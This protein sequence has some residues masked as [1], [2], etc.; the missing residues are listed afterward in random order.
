MSDDRAPNHEIGAVPSKPKAILQAVKALVP[1]AT[2]GR[3]DHRNPG[4][5]LRPEWFD[6]IQVNLSAVERRAG[7]M[8]PRR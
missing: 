3:G 2:T 4:T 8:G 1:R 6:G 7:T 5:T